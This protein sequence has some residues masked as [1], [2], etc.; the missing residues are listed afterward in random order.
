MARE[1][2]GISVLVAQLILAE[3]GI[4][5]RGQGSVEV[6]CAGQKTCII[7]T[8]EVFVGA[9]GGLGAIGLALQ[10]SA[11][12]AARPTRHYLYGNQ[13]VAAERC[14]DGCAI[15]QS[16]GPQL[17]ANRWIKTLQEALGRIHKDSVHGGR[18]S[19]LGLA[20]N[21]WIEASNTGGGG[22]RNITVTEVGA[23]GKDLAV[24]QIGQVRWRGRFGGTISVAGE[25][26]DAQDGVC[27]KSRGRKAEQEEG[28][29]G[30]HGNDS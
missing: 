30:D 2:T 8:G 4:H 25:D 12:F 1:H 10:P 6:A 7:F 26:V 27:G 9:H 23:R 22:G 11:V 29:D 28:L 20:D 24:T 18:Y 3:S 15:P 17:R 13:L 5:E 14:L 19:N 16:L 21:I